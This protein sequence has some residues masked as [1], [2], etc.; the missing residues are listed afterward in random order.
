MSPASNDQTRRPRDLRSGE[1]PDD[2]TRS[3]ADDPT[4]GVDPGED[5]ASGPAPGERPGLHGTT[6]RRGALRDPAKGP[7]RERTAP[8]ALLLVAIAV[9]A[10]IAALWWL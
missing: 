4:H 3:R 8:A 5:R 6:V 7:I 9:V 10:I 2:P 1:A